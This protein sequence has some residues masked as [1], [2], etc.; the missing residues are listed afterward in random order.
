MAQKVR[1]EGATHLHTPQYVADDVFTMI[2]QALATYQLLLYLNA[3]ERRERDC[4]WNNS[5][6]GCYGT[7]RPVDDR[8]LVQHHRYSRRPRKRH[9][10]HKSGLKKRLAD[11]EED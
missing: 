1:R 5:Y 10:Y 11:I 4:Y 7:S 3:D 8:L 6:G 2:R 9:R